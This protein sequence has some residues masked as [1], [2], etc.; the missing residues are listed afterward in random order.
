MKAIWRDT[1]IAESQKTI[2]LEGNHYFPPE[3]LVQEYFAF[4]NHKSTCP[5][6]GQASYKSLS[7]NGEMLQQASLRAVQALREL[8]VLAVSLRNLLHE[9]EE[10][11]RKDLGPEEYGPSDTI[12]DTQSATGRK[13]DEAFANDLDAPVFSTGATE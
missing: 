2:L 13:D 8:A 10:A 5:W 11:P 12:Y 4:S 9:H 1:V 6:K 3:S 7:I